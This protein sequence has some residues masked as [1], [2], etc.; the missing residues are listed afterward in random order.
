MGFA[1]KVS[2]KGRKAV[3]IFGKKMKLI[4]LLLL[5][6]SL[7]IKLVKSGQLNWSGKLLV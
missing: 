7:P 4:R 2:K 5:F 6:R 1:T 3:D